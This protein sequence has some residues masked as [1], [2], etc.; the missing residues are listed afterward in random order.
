MGGRETGIC[1]EEGNK[2]EKKEK[3]KKESYDGCV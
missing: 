3:K 2:K 1:L